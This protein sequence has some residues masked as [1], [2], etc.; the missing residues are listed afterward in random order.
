[1]T[2]SLLASN[3]EV[4]WL[5]L[6]SHPDAD[7][8]STRDHRVAVLRAPLSIQEHTDAHAACAIC[9]KANTKRRTAVSGQL[10]AD[11]LRWVQ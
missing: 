6:A 4:D 7:G 2:N 9:S 3:A 10:C 1:M 8:L 11:K 5:T